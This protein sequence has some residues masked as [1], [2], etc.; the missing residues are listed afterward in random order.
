[1]GCTGYTFRVLKTFLTMIHA[2]FDESYSHWLRQCKHRMCLLTRGRNQIKNSIRREKFNVWGEILDVTFPVSARQRTLPTTYKRLCLIPW[3][4][5]RS[6]A[7]E[8]WKNLMMWFHIRIQLKN[9][10][11]LDWVR[12]QDSRIPKKVRAV[13]NQFIINALKPAQDDDKLTTRNALKGNDPKKYRE[14][15]D[16][17][18]C[19]LK[20]TGLRTDRETG[21]QTYFACN[22]QLKIETLW[23]VYHCKVQNTDDGV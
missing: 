8:V 21:R 12:G 3:N 1:M 15:I 14:A 18:I 6:K 23:K 16:K 17:E 11:S 20:N 7:E 13:R 4:S 22:V 2:T 19:E 9:A 10:W 5:K